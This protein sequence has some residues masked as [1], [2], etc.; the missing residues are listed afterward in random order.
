MR[1]RL[2]LNP[3]ALRTRQNVHPHRRAG[4][5]RGDSRPGNRAR[6]PSAPCDSRQGGATQRSCRSSAYIRARGLLRRPLARGAACRCRSVSVVLAW[7]VPPSWCCR[8]MTL[9]WVVSL[10]CCGLHVRTGV[11]GFVVLRTLCLGS[12]PRHP[13]GH[14]VSRSVT[15]RAFRFVPWRSVD[16]TLPGC[17]GG[18]LVK[19]TMTPEGHK[20]SAL[21]APL[22]N[23]AGPP[24][25]ACRACTR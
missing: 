6:H 15:S 17:A 25:W 7:G 9:R 16:V 19:A 12:V 1:H 3:L 23:Q 8:V 18:D 2:R 10:P 22:P 24:Q 4:C 20:L 11:L 5:A 21:R 13:F 14:V